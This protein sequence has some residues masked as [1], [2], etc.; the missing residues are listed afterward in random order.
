MSSKIAGYK[1]LNDDFKHNNFQYIL[2]ENVLLD[3][4]KFKQEVDCSTGGF[5]FCQL[6]DICLW[7]QYSPNLAYICEVELCLDSQVSIGNN[8]IKTD[9]FILKNKKTIGNFL[10]EFNLIKEA[11][12]TPYNLKYLNDIKNISKEA[13]FDC[14]QRDASCY[15][16]IKKPTYEMSKYIVNKQSSNLVY[17]K[18]QSE[19]LCLIAILDDPLNIAHCKPQNRSLCLK[20]IELDGWAILNIHVQT[21][22]MCLK[23][24]EKNPDVIKFLDRACHTREVGVLVI[25]AFF[26]KVGQSLRTSFYYKHCNWEL[27]FGSSILPVHYPKGLGWLF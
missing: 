4:E 23:A 26:S 7:L 10:E 9:K 14:L 6:Q 18:D 16:H 24:I 12:L 19:E 27:P 21:E 3:T 15:V 17:V 11:L 13:I 8:K 5:Y 22:E 25:T 20:A 2:G 1:L